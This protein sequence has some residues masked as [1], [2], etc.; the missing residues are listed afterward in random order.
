ME[1]KSNHT[2]LF[3]EAMGNYPTGVSVVTAMDESGEPIGLTVN[4]LASVS[5]DPLLILWSIDENVSTYDTFRKIDHFA[6]NILSG[7]QK[8]LAILFSTDHDNRFAFFGCEISEL[9]LSIF[10]NSFPIVEC[11]TYKYIDIGGHTNFFGVL[12]SIE[13]DDELPLMY[14]DRKMGE[15]PMD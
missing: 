11:K 3:K 10:S 6:V 9:C 13:G 2:S 12:I 4:S 14:H 1:K 5:I 15:F 7:D 8:D